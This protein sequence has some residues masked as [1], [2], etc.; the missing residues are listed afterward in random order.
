MA[1]TLRRTFSYQSHAILK[2][3]IRRGFGAPLSVEA[4][5]LELRKY[6]YS[7]KNDLLQ[8]RQ[9]VIDRILKEASY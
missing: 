5:L 9:Q 2:P 4:M 1:Q 6:L 8:P 7:A 3:V